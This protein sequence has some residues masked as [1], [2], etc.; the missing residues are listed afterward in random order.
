[1]PFA[2]VEAAIARIARGEPVVV[3]DDAD[4]ENEGDLILAAEKATSNSIAFILNHTSGVLC[5]ALP[6]ARCDALNLPLMVS[7]GTDAQ[8]TAFTV[9]VDARRGTT[10][11]ISA[12]DRATT[13]RALASG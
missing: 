2:H 3:V 4:R 7:H 12:A 11:G 10:T 9:T 8:G 1:M 6:G 13:I 5:V